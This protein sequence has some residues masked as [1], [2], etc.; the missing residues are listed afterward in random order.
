MKN[1]RMRTE[2]RNKILVRRRSRAYQRGRDRPQIGMRL[3]RRNISM[4]NRRMRTEVRYK[5]VMMRRRKKMV[6]GRVYQCY[7][8]RHHSKSAT[9]S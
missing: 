2:V 1:K 3:E 5:I 8:W 7:Y 9:S 4:K 6:R